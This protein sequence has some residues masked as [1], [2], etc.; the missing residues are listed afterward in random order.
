[1]RGKETGEESYLK[2]GEKVYIEKLRENVA[3]RH[4]KIRVEVRRKESSLKG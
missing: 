4:K 3:K 2:K 1:L